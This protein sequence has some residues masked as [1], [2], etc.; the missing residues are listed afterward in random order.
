MYGKAVPASWPEL[1]KRAAYYR[2]AGRASNT[3]CTYST[4]LRSFFKF[5]EE[6]KQ[7]VTLPVSDEM[8]CGFVTWL[9]SKQLKMATIKV[10]LFAV[11]AAQLDAGYSF[12]P[13]RSRHSVFMTL[14]G[15]R[16]IHGDSSSRKAAITIDMLSRMAKHVDLA[17]KDPKQKVLISAIWAA[18]LVGFY[19]ILRKDNITA[20]KKDPFNPS[21]GLRRTDMETWICSPISCG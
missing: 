2:D 11:R 17:R 3:T 13:W 19:G 20:G 16:R 21:R 10:Y 6:Y 15:V 18:M 5:G 1:L 12:E 7:E 8:L 4:G 9:A 14:Q